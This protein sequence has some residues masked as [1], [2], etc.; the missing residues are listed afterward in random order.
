MWIRRCIIDDGNEQE[1]DSKVNNISLYI[2]QKIYDYKFKISPI[3]RNNSSE[4]QCLKKFL[5]DNNIKFE[6]T[7]NIILIGILD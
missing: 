3:Y 5:T 2:S 4:G 6:R 7:R 1:V